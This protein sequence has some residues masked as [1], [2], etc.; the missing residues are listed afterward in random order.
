MVAVCVSMWAFWSDVREGWL[1]IAHRALPGSE[2]VLR[3]LSVHSI[4]A[5]LGKAPLDTLASRFV[6][7]SK[8]VLPARGPT[9]LGAK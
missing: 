2:Y 7:P 1:A 8:S 4:C 3:T 5:A 6:A 9:A